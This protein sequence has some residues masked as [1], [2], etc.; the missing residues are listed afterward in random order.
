MNLIYSISNCI[1][2]HNNVT[3]AVDTVLVYCKDVNKNK[4][5]Y[6]NAHTVIIANENVQ[7][8]LEIYDNSS[9]KINVLF[10]GIDSISRLNFIRTMPKTFKYVEENEW[11]PLVGYNKMDDNTFPNLMAIFT[12]MN[13][14]RQ[15][16]VCNPKTVGP[17]D[18]CPIIMYDFRRNGYITAYGEDEGSISTFNYNKK[19]F[20]TPPTD[21]YFRPYILASEKLTIE[22]IDDMN[23]CTGPETSG[24]RILNLAKDFSNKFKDY[25]HFGFFWMNSFSHNKINSPSRMDEKVKEFLEGLADDGILNNDIVVFLSDHGMRFGK[26]RLTYTGWLEERLPFIYVWFPPWF[27]E[28]FPNEYNNFKRNRHKL[29]SPYDLHMTLQ[30]IFLLSGLNRSVIPSEACPKCKSLLE[31][32]ETERS[33]EDVGVVDHWCTCAGYKL[34]NLTSS[35]SSTLGNYVINE[36]NKIVGTNA[37]RSKC[38][39]YSLQKIISTSISEKL[40]YRKT[41]Y[42]LIKIETYPKALFETTVMYS[43]DI[44]DKKFDITGD[45][46]RLDLYAPHSYCMKDSYLKK[47][48][49]CR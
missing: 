13:Q 9:S 3:L 47:Y 2:F 18:K 45:I 34:V 48:C 4:T 26:I 43:G 1:T 42:I 21:Y 22:R 35:E 37:T 29:T 40:P 33:C 32:I 25:P 17:L 27:Q 31:E 12:G 20:S 30:H 8:K 11:L 39:Q 41:N 19:G 49:Y 24:E 10:I 44:V 36:I 23:Y 15:Y 16:S 28:K 6:E 14:T 38:A 7:K 46:S 5:V